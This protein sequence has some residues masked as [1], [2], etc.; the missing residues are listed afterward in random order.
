MRPKVIVDDRELGTQVVKELYKLGA[1][2][3]AKRLEIG[4]YVVSSDV[5][6]ERK[7]MHDF[8]SSI[9]DGRLF[10]QVE[11]M[12]DNYPRPMLLIEGQ[13]YERQVHPNAV[14]GAILYLA[15]QRVPII[16]S[17]DAGE[18]AAYIFLEAKREQFERKKSISLHARKPMTD[19]Q[20][21]EYI[22]ASLPGVGLQLAR[23]LLK[24]FGTVER[25]FTANVNELKQV[26]KIGEKKAK[27]IR[28]ILTKRYEG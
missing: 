2:I 21:Q 8:V 4:D 6:I 25:V 1:I 5:C 16:W 3:E 17:R 27:E 10:Q 7:T 26:E 22:V 12:I 13:Y 20:W 15:E 9:V 24:Y 11:Q 14:R 23:N 18:S 19:K 28:R